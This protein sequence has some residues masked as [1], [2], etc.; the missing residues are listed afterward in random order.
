[1]VGPTPYVTCLRAGPTAVPPTRPQ[2]PQ[3]CETYVF[4]IGLQRGLRAAH[5]AWPFAHSDITSLAPSAQDQVGDQARPPGLVRGAEPG[6]GVA[7]EVLV[8]R[9]EVVPGWVRL[10]LLVMAEDWPPAVAVV[11]EDRDEPAG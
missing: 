10:E 9:D 5:T 6:A 7:V 1:V 11:G 8:E 4:R 3:N 2:A